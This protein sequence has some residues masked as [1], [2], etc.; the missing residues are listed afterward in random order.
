MTIGARVLKTGLAVALAIYISN[1][2]GFESPI[3][4]AIAA[5]AV[6]PTISRSWQYVGEQLQ[7]NLLGAIVALLMSQFFG[8]TAM[9]VGLVCII[10]ILISIRLGMESTINLTLVTVVAV[11]EAGNESWQFALTRLYMVFI[12]MGAAIVVNLTVVPPKPR[13]QF[14]AQVQDAFQQL[15]L[16]LR[17]AISNELREDIHR[18]AKQNLTETL[19]KLDERYTLFEDEK[20]LSKRKQLTNYRELVVSKHLLKALRRGEDLLDM[21]EEHYFSA[22]DAREWADTFD[23]QVE[24][25]VKFHEQLLLKREGKLKAKYTPEFDGLSEQELIHQLKQHLN[26]APQEN[27][28]FVYVGS[29]MFEYMYQLRQL[30]KVIDQI[31]QREGE[32]Q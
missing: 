13:Q 6:Q 18:V 12:G 19:K 26:D 30:N 11:M 32:E 17:M 21:I 3:I 14:I 1:L 5:I 24:Q 28:A 8:Q 29:A 27:Y 22:A 31:Q 10:V 2:L 25:L 9:S 7:T 15:S 16:L 23:S 4:A 20:S